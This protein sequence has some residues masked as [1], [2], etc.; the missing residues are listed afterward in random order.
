MRTKN[1]NTASSVQSTH[2]GVASIESNDPDD[3]TQKRSNDDS[4]V[5]ESATSSSDND[6]SDEDNLCMN[7]LDDSASDLAASKT[8]VASHH[9]KADSLCLRMPPRNPKRLRLEL[10][11]DTSK[12]RI[13]FSN[14]RLLPIQD[15]SRIQQRLFSKHGM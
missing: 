12:T 11:R 3:G 10:D 7:S 15:R 5:S 2:R 14:R 1:T 8:T 6:S 4:S 13:R 9:D